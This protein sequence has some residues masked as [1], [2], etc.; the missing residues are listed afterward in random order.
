[1]CLRPASLSLLKATH[2]AVTGP[3]EKGRGQ[4]GQ[5]APS[6]RYFGKTTA[7]NHPAHFLGNPLYLFYLSF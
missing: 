7:P 6:P 2:P 1:M 4:C 5:R 3:E